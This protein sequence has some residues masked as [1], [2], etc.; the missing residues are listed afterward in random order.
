MVCFYYLVFEFVLVAGMGLLVWISTEGL[1]PAGMRWLSGN[2]KQKP[3][4]YII[5]KYEMML[6]KELGNAARIKK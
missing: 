2:P 1:T 6:R 5:S 3:L 4:Q